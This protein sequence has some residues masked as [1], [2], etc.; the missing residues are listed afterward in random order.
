MIG[1][2]CTSIKRYNSSGIVDYFAMFP[3]TFPSG[4]TSPGGGFAVDPKKLRSEYRKLQSINHP[5]LNL[6]NNSEDKSSLI[7]KAYET[8]SDPLKR[9]QYILLIQSGIDLSND[10]V[11]KSLQF[12]DK[13]M[14]FEMMEIHE[15]LENIM[16]EKE[17]QEMK[18]ENQNK[19]KELIDQLNK[20]FDQKDWD[21]AA[22][23]TIRL[24]YCYNIKNTLK[25]WQP[26]QPVTLTH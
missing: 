25:E 21:N 24:K 10:E 4:K 12:Q 15:R 6:G 11:G 17:L 3:K 20:Y 13:A 26:G 2:V 22:L 7:N 19:I 9:A 16:N 1:R 23:A 5:D 18:S 14:L 8:L